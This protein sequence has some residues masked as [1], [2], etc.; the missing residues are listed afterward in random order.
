MMQTAAETSTADEHLDG[1]GLPDTFLN[2]YEILNAGALRW[3]VR[4]YKV[5]PPAGRPSHAE[6]GNAKQAIWRPEEKPCVLPGAG[7]RRGRR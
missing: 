4:L 1:R 2:C 7:L 6:R 5:R 3:N